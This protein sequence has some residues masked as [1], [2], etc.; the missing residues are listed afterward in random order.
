[1]SNRGRF[2][3]WV[4]VASAVSLLAAVMTS[5]IFPL[6]RPGR[7]SAPNYLRRD[8]AHRTGRPAG[9]PAKSIPSRHL[10]FKARPSRL[11]EKLSQGAGRKDLGRCFVA[12]PWLGMT[13][14]RSDCLSTHRTHPL[15]C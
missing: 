3:R 1:M 13:F 2:Q 5:P 15:R 12:S 4:C 7:A 8:F 10:S 11:N 6:P 9:K 14:E